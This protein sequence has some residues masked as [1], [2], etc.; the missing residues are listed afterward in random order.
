MLQTNVIYCGDNLIKLKN[1]PDNSVDVVYVDPPFNSNRHYE[2]F[3]GDKREKVA[4]DDRFGDPLNYINWME[5]RLHEIRRVL[6]PTGSFFFHCDW[7]ICHYIKV[8]L[9]QIFGID[10]FRN[11]IIWCYNRPGNS[12]MKNFTRSHDTI[13]YYVKSKKTPFYADPVR[14]PYSQSSLAR[15]G[16]SKTGISGEFKE[17]VCVLN[18]NGK[19]PPDWWDDI[20]P[21]R[22]NSKERIGYPTQKPVSLIDRILLCSSVE[23]DIVLDAFCGCGTT[24][25]SSHKLK[26]KWIGI[27]ISPTACRVMSHRLFEKVGL[28]EGQD[29]IIRDLPKTEDELRRMHHYDF[30]NWAVTA[31]GGITNGKGADKGIDGKVYLIDGE[32]P[33]LFSRMNSFFPVQVKQRDKV[34]RPDVDSFETVL[35]REKKVEGFIVAF[36]FSKESYKEVSRASSEDNLNIHLVTVQNLIERAESS[37]KNGL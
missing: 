27:D 1:L 23:G 5:P 19:F 12:R 28:V 25:E 30:Q 8:L 37:L 11:E 10:N 36:S 6:K 4:F 31:L 34:G 32:Y 3:W 15:E 16:Y 9:D 14:R 24:L 29:F 7:H 18:P 13:L 2:L 26:R 35:R 21:L 17:K 22:P 20:P 33:N